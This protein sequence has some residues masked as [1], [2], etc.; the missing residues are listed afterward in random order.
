M[1]CSKDCSTLVFSR[2]KV[3][4]DNDVIVEHTSAYTGTKR[5]PPRGGAVMPDP[6]TPYASGL[7]GGAANF[8]VA[9][10]CFTGFNRLVQRGL[11]VLV[12]CRRRHCRCCCACAGQQGGDQCWISPV[13]C[14]V[15]RRLPFRTPDGSVV[16]ALVREWVNIISLDRNHA[17]W[18]WWGVQSSAKSRRLQSVLLTSV[19]CLHPLRS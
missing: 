5:W 14:P 3:T 18:C 17:G 2:L 9:R 15:Q 13:R 19:L 4:N 7:R 8:A 1:V 10:G 12:C 11:A 6:I 16:L